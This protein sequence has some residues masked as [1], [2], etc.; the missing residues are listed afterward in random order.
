MLP[1][2][3][4][5]CS[6]DEFGAHPPSSHRYVPG[7]IVYQPGKRPPAWS[8]DGERFKRGPRSL[9][10]SSHQRFT[11]RCPKSGSGMGETVM[12]IFTKTMIAL[13]A[14]FV[15]GAFSITP[16]MAATAKV[17]HH[18]RDVGQ[19][20]APVANTAR[21]PAVRPFTDEERALFDR[22]SRVLGN[23]R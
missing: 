22:T 12:L 5:P 23:G 1:D 6:T 8:K 3:R 16:A 21:A 13:S 11:A 10:T 4:C 17:R 14:A 2:H 18:A 19:R 20:Y 15:L 9:A 7:H